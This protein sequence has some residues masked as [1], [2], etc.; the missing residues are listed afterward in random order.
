VLNH[1][2]VCLRKDLQ[3]LK[4]LLFKS[5]PK[6]FLQILL[7]P[8][9]FLLP[10][11]AFGASFD[12]SI[13][14]LSK[15][16]SWICQQPKVSELDE[17]IAKI[18]TENYKKLSPVNRVGYLNSQYEWLK[19]W[20][21]ACMREENVTLESAG[22][23]ECAQRLYEQRIA[24]LP[25]RPLKNQWLVFKLAKYNMVKAD[26]KS[27]P[28]NIKMLDHFL[29]YPKIETANLSSQNMQ[30][31]NQVNTWVT[32]VIQKM[33]L[34]NRMSLNEKDM[35]SFLEMEL[36][37]VSPDILRL[38]ARYYFYGFGAHG[39]SLFNQYHFILSQGRELREED[40]LKGPWQVEIAQDVYDKIQ[41]KAPEMVL[42]DSPKNVEPSIK[43]LQNWDFNKEGFR[44]Q[45]SPYELTAYAAGAVQVSIDWT[46][47][48]AYLT[49]YAKTQLPLLYEKH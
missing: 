38:R 31:A 49:D 42:V 28:D 11:G 10:H 30:L 48:D 27:V 35:D 13:P 33:G 4:I 24:L 5:M 18:Y 29:V 7:V 16:E 21:Q 40:L 32:S 25:V 8:F 34:K 39:N 17:D 45:F 46:K 47:M 3:F 41:I 19:Y 44:F 12:C 20:P 23:A 9:F 6:K 22:V 1:K 15:I 36:E 43:R 2:G 37:Q 14:T 26:K